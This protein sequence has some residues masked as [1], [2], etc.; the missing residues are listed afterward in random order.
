MTVV[1]TGKIAKKYEPSK[2]KKKD[3]EKDSEKK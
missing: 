3:S 2:G 1:V